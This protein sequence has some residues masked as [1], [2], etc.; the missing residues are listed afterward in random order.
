[1]LENVVWNAVVIVWVLGLVYLGAFHANPVAAVVV[2][3]VG[4]VAGWFAPGR[5]RGV[6]RP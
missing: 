5:V 1:M 4:L 3:G 2:F 6:L